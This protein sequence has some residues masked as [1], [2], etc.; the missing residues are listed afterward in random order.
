M[1]TNA[2]LKKHGI[3]EM[4]QTPGKPQVR[5]VLDNIKC[6]GCGKT[7]SKAMIDL[8]FKNVSVDPEQS[9]VEMDGPVEAAQLN[10][11]LHRLRELGYPLVDTEEGLKA[12]A[13][14]ARSYLSCAIG[15]MD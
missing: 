13:L 1:N 12:I 6:G 5:L 10:V 11:A 4:N 9:F 3:I 8:G 7:I 15:K 2:E 14:K